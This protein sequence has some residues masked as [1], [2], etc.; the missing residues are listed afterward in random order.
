MFEK[1]NRF[2][3]L[4]AAILIGQPFSVLLAIIQ[5][6]HGSN[7]IDTQAIYMELL[8]PEQRIGNQEILDLVFTVIKNLCYIDT[9]ALTI[10]LNFT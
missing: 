1:L 6:K 10:P 7:R 9:N 4:I 5:I 2:Q 3:I 8:H